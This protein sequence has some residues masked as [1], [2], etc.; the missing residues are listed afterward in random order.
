[1]TTYEKRKFFERLCE[2]RTAYQA[3]EQAATKMTIE[4]A[5][6]YGNAALTESIVIDLQPTKR[7]A[8]PRRAR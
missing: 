8:S 1:M 6:A 2:L 4:A 5:L 3:T 7:V